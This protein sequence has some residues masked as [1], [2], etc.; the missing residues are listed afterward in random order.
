MRGNLLG[1]FYIQ[2]KTFFHPSNLEVG[3]HN[4][5][6]TNAEK[7]TDTFTKSSFILNDITF[8]DY[9]MVVIKYLFGIART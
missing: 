6:S 4:T 7:I 2:I 1:Q 9:L 3:C 8:C 5:K